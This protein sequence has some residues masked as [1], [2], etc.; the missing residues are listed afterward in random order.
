[1]AKGRY[2]SVV[3]T[4]CSTADDKRFNEWYNAN[5]IPILM[6]YPGVKKVTRYKVQGEA[7]NGGCYLAIYE[8]D[9]A[10]ARAGQNTSDAFKEA[11]AEMQ[12]SWPNGGVE[13]K[14]M[15]AYDPIKTWEQ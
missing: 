12:Q 15:G 8:Y 11:M 9:S 4:N 2:I 6:K 10:E 13:I 1:M 7:P 5:H 14:W 3:A